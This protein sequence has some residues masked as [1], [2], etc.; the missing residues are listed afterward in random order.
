ML[1]TSFCNVS[2]LLEMSLENGQSSIKSDCFL[3][4]FSKILSF[5][6]KQVCYVS[7]KYYYKSNKEYILAD[8]LRTLN[9]LHTVN[10]ISETF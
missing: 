9:E 5:F 4:C 8:V 6:V 1:V 2:E 10:C 7:E 3:P